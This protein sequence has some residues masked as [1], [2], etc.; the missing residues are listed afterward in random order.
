MDNKDFAT[1]QRYTPAEVAAHLGVGRAKVLGWIR[2]GAL[3]A[4]DAHSGAEP[5]KRRLWRISA[6]D[7]AAFEASRTA[8]APPPALT[9][10]RR[11]PA[12]NRTAMEFIQ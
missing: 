11:S 2:S 3:R 5:G 6:V 10:R 4:V 8:Q 7:L 12:V 9:S 1:K